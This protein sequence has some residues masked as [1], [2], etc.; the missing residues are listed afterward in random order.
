MLKDKYF[1]F[2]NFQIIDNG[3]DHKISCFLKT[4]GNISKF[5]NSYSITDVFIFP[6]ENIIILF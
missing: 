6:D 1:S 2:I 3:G 5:S 4:L